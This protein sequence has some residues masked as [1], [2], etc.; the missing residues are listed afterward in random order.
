MAHETPTRQ[1]DKAA[2]ARIAGYV[3]DLR[4]RAISEVV[5]RLHD[6]RLRALSWHERGTPPR[7]R[8]RI[9]DD[10]TLIPEDPRD[11][12]LLP[13]E[14]NLEDL[15]PAHLLANEARE[16]LRTA[17]FTDDEVDD[18][19]RAFVAHRGAGDFGDLVAW[20]RLEEEPT[21]TPPP[22]ATAPVTPHL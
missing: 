13:V 21:P 19:A 17:G 20:I 10:G 3:W 9:W 2:V 4:A 6:G 14:L 7:L 18:W 1:R 5:V 15:E 12:G 11:A 8:R 16:E 22:N